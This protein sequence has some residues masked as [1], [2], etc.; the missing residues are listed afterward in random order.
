MAAEISGSG[1]VSSIQSTGSTIG[2]QASIVLATLQKN[3]EQQEI[4][5]RPL[6]IPD[7]RMFGL[8]RNVNMQM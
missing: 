6:K 2:R 3:A 1:Q 7:L 5:N 4:A 8:G